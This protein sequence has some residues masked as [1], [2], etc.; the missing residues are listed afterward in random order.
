MALVTVLVWLLAVR[1]A[2]YN[3]KLDGHIKDHDCL[4]IF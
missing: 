2:L 3:I 1:P 4:D